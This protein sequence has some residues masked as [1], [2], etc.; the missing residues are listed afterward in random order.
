MLL[1]RAVRVGRSWGP[2]SRRSLLSD[3]PVD[4]EATLSPPLSLCLLLSK[5]QGPLRPPPGL[6]FEAAGSRSQVR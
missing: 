3:L 6:T 2:D 5:M 4:P 1:K